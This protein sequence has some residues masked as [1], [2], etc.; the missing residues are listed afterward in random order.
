MNV[1]TVVLQPNGKVVVLGSDAMGQ[2][3]IPD[4]FFQRIGVGTYHVFGITTTGQLQAWGL[5]GNGQTTVPNNLLNPLQVTGGMDFSVALVVDVANSN[6]P[7]VTASTV[8]LSRNPALPTYGPLTS[9]SGAT[10]WNVGDIPAV[11][12]TDI[13][14]LA[15]TSDT[16]GVVHSDNTV[17]LNQ[18]AG[19]TP[20]TLPDDAKTNVQQLGL[21]TAF[22]AV[23][24]RDHTLVVWGNAAPTVPAFFM[25]NVIEIAV[26]Q[27]HLMVLT[28]DGRVWSNQFNIGAIEPVRHIAAG[29]TYAV[30]LLA[31]GKVRVWA[32]DNNQGLLSIPVTADNISEISA[33][34]YHILALRSDGRVVAWGAEQ[35]DNSQ[36]DVPYSALTNVV[37]IATGNRMS[38]ALRE[39]NSVVV[40]GI[41]PANTA[42]TLATI[43][44]NKNAV[45]I[46]AGADKI[47]V[48]TDGGPLNGAPTKT[49]IPTQTPMTFPT[50]TIRPS[51]NEVIANQIGWFT[52]NDVVAPQQF[53]G[54]AGPYKCATSR[55]CPQIDV[56]GT[57]KHGV[58]FAP[59]R[60]DELV[61]NTTVNLAGT[62]FTVS[63]WLRRDGIQAE[64]VVI[65]IGK[66]A[67]FRQYLTMGFDSENR[68]YCN[69][70]GDDLRS[71]TWYNDT[72]WHHYACTFDKTTL[73]RQL[74]RD[75]Q[76]IAQNIAGGAFNPPASQIILGQRYDSMPGLS[77]SLDEF[78]LY[79]RVLTNSELQAYTAMPA[80]DH[81]ADA[82]FEDG[83]IQGI[84][85]NRS[86]LWCINNM[87]CPSTSVQTHDEDALQF[88]GIE[89]VQY[90]DST[91][92]LNKGFTIAY[93]AKRGSTVSKAKVITTQGSGTSRIIM[94][95]NA[96]ENAFCRVNSTDVV[97][98]VV[99]DMVWHHYTCT[100]DAKSD[101]I[102]L[103]VD[104][105]SPI[106]DVGTDYTGAGLLLIGRITD[107][108]TSS[109]TG[110]NGW[111]DDLMIYNTPLLQSTIGL[112][113][114]STTPPSP[115]TP[116]VLTPNQTMSPTWTKTFTVVPSQTP[117]PTMNPSKTRLAMS[118]T[119]TLQSYNAYTPT[120]TLTRLM[121]ATSTANAS[122]TKAVTLT[123]NV[124]TATITRTPFIVTRTML[125]KLS[126]TWG[127]QTLTATQRSQAATD[128]AGTATRVVA[129]T[130]TS[131]SGTRVAATLTAYPAPP[132]PTAWGPAYP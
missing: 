29:P 103:Y 2:K 107:A 94:G 119:M 26:N 128:V 127:A 33:G 1:N 54:L 125:A 93:W 74:F 101:V 65:S 99:S 59:T 78:I 123:S 83:I 63:Y 104:G 102:T 35:N 95:F 22:G 17:T 45:A 50:A 72:N 90:S 47:A 14:S 23:L 75:G 64:D 21:G 56:N 109:V 13:S 8:P 58:D 110:F 7:T 113:Y 98:S 40:W 81:I 131:E 124:S 38:I 89:Q 96:N 114:N 55:N 49:R 132:P 9:F 122:E 112:I 51:S 60:S 37:A 88:T 73:V 18:S 130:R 115:I 44:S 28:A 48:I 120:W 52:M 10:V 66:L 111:I 27:S 34:Q 87:P 108:S 46:A 3:N 121:T 57:I 86:Q 62:S 97:A 80:T 76:L 129:L 106:S 36:A 92:A 68:V 30:V 43:A 82:N 69:F 5:N 79:N 105:D 70:F 100:Y 42:S 84:S 117:T 116:V 24:K 16:I 77:G 12:D 39:D 41:V 19:I 20:Q 53:I 85:P 126:P 67:T 118:K 91:V 4:G 11:S 32:P 61:S 31:N 6:T 15:V 25:Q 71:V